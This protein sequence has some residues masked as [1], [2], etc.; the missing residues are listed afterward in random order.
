MG[1]EQNDAVEDPG[2][3]ERWNLAAL[4]LDVTCFSLGMAFIDSSAVL[5]LLLERLGASG[6]VIGASA[7]LRSLGLSGF[8][9]F[10]A[11]ALHG[12]KRQKPWLVFVAT[13]TRLPLLAMPLFLLRAD[14]SPTV[15]SIALWAIILI[16]A[17][18]A[19][20]DGLGYVPWME[21]VARA[22]SRRIRGRFFA[23]TQIVSGL[24]SIAIGLLVVRTTLHSRLIPFPLNYAIL[25][26][27][28]ALLF[29][30]SLAGVVLIKEP[31]TSLKDDYDKD[32][33]V[34]FP[35]LGRYFRRVPHLLRDNPIFVKLSMIQL[36]LGF[37]A[38][39]A[40]FYVLYATHRFHVGDEWGGIYQAFQALGVVVLTPLWTYLSERKSP[41]SAVRALAFA[42]MLTPLAALSI[43]S[44]SPWLFGV[45][46]FLMGGSLGWG[47]WIVTNHYLLSHVDKHER[48][49]YVALI[50]LLFAPSALFPY[51][52]GMLIR[53]GSLLTVSTV[54]I[55]FVI[56]GAVV[57]V[58]FLLS[59]G[60]AHVE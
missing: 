47:L 51:F 40:P 14:K 22:F 15:R 60:L 29:Q 13:V 6:V 16:L 12:K 48:P 4:M 49:V 2:R 36:F 1:N 41:A 8:Q 17:V 46:F 19:L 18:W 32:F 25:T 7:A 20:G 56:T 31:G 53:H 57:S 5:P 50:N 23:S 59:L 55:L 9:I 45:V 3:H 44:L 39:A 58:G 35:T 52:G 33:R 34:Q 37:G 11:Y 10:V 43:G 38:A 27:L 54:P 26:G 21:I 30:A 42:V 28:A 24:G